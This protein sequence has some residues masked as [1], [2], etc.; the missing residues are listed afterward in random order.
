LS[1]L[2]GLKLLTNRKLIATNNK[3]VSLKPRI[4]FKLAS[5]SV[6]TLIQT[7][8][9]IGL[10]MFLESLNIDV[11]CLSETRIQDPSE[12]L[13]IRSPS[14]SSESL[15]HVCLSADPVALSGFADVDVSLSARALSSTG[16]LY[17]H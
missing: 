4:L 16:R 2:N 6:R 11:C 1:Y 8:Q 13:Q 3:P 17:P 7:G 9:H 10:V 5:F 12:V 15:F 14:V